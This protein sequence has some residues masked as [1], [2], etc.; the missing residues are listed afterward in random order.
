M[1]FFFKDQG[2]TYWPLNLYKSRSEL[3]WHIVCHYA[4]AYC[5]TVGQ[6][7]EGR[8]KEEEEEEEGRGGNVLDRQT[9]SCKP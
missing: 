5:N 8:K 6:G 1:S 2:F 4:G 3:Y 7:E 9:T